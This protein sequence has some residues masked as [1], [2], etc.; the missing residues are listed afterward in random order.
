MRT[1]NL[2]Y[3]DK[4]SFNSFLK[5]HNFL[6]EKSLLVQ[7]FSS[8][9]QKSKLQYVL[10]DITSL[11]PNSFIIGATTDGEI[12]DN[13][14]STDQIVISLTAFEKAT[15]KVASAQNSGD[16]F[17]C[18]AEIAKKLVQNDTKA[19]FLFSDG[20]YTNG[21]IFLNGVKSIS[22]DITLAGGMA[23]DAAHFK[24]TYI[25]SNDGVISKGAVGV[26]VN[27]ETLHI[28]TS[29]SFNW[30][31]IGKTLRVTKAVENRVYEIDGE[32]AVSIYSKYLGEEMAGL[33]PAIGIEFPLIITRD[34]V[35]I[36]RAVLGKE[37]DDSLIFAGNVLEGDSVR[38]GYGN[39][40]MILKDSTNVKET[41]SAQ[42]PE[43]IF[44]YSCMARRRFLQEA[45]S[46]ELTPLAEIAPTVGF[47]TYGEFYKAKKCEL[48]NQ[49]MTIIAMS[50]VDE[51]GPR[52]FVDKLDNATEV[53]DASI[54]YKAL[55]H[56]I[57]ETSNELENINN[58]LEKLVQEKTSALQDKIA[59]LE[60]ASK[61]KSDFLAGMSHEIRT[62]LNAMLGFVDILKAGEKDKERSRRFTIIKNSGKSLLTIINDILDFSK[63]ESGKM[64]LERRKFATKK[65]F[66][67]M[68]QL[69]YEKAKED[70]I[71]LKLGFSENLPRF[72]IGD[73]VRIKQVAANL[74]SNA[75]KFTPKGGYISIH[76]D[77]DDKKKELKFS[78]EDSG[79][80]IDEKNLKKIFEAFTQEDSTTTR[81]FGGTGLGLSISTSL[82]NSMEGHI[83]VK[84]V[85]GKGSKFS[86]VLPSIESDEEEKSENLLIEKIDLNQRLD[87]KVLL[88]EDNKTNQMLMNIVLGDLDI[89]VTLAENGLEAVEKFK[90]SKYDLILMDENMPRMNGIEA[91]KIILDIEEKESLIHTPIVALTANALATDRAKFLGA[92][93]DEFVSK[94][95]D[96][97]LFVR[98]LHMFL[99]PKE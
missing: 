57:E 18:G 60:Y 65:P 70:G 81:R 37:D 80:G 85:L 69:F 94:P 99:K 46:V 36:A 21:E 6:S 48:L 35:K 87:A 17:T 25:L 2:Y 13:R 1:E 63:I 96:H 7:V 50:E 97:E 40:G 43:S 89:D 10:S 56:L 84:S 4:N 34:G 95:I 64:I 79:V 91:T 9:L 11:L 73:I 47:F 59:E 29:Y 51:V 72:F 82:I 74:L 68:G 16:S 62:P 3:T 66:K 61:V 26:S 30:Q 54:T 71:E 14:V 93:M 75:I 92:G 39:T 42:M 55:S 58:N 76:V 22:N 45:I 19:L 78:V 67:E 49:T 52:N 38:F 98:V 88:V 53:S 15:L 86:F 77:F 12:L 27:S 28:K 90:E 8:E 41:F 83:E 32:S 31:E 44:I 24:E 20:L 33:L 5:E 23:G